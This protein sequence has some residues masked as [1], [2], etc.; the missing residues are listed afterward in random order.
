MTPLEIVPEAA[1]DLLLVFVVEFA[2]LAH[3]VEVLHT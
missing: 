1:A 3:T 2:L